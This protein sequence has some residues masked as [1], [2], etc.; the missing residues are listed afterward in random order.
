MFVVG[1]VHGHL[2]TLV[3]LL[4]TSGLIGD[5]HAWT[6]STAHLW[7]IGDLFDRGPDGVGVVEL[8]MRLEREATTAGG[9]VGA[10]LGNHDAMILAARRFGNLATSGPG[11]SFLTD[12][13]LNGGQD[14][15][16][17]RLGGRQIAWLTDRP[18]MALADGALLMHADATFYERYGA[19]VADVN[20]GIQH[21]LESDDPAAWDRLLDDF[22]QR[23]AFWE[24]PAE[25]ERLLQRY[26]GRC[27]IHGH[28]PI[29]KMTG[30]RDTDVTAALRYAG[31][32]CINVDGGIY[33]GGPGF[34]FEWEAAG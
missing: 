20:M 27:I 12:W 11:G 19:S 32:R 15:D 8:L 14:G 3:R 4:R 17:A 1:D 9:L 7:F 34:V 33:R 25:A 10:L 21:I 29:A 18:A 2:D 31:G 13:H 6:G 16:L 5:T 23:L 26:G 22:R 24:R 28:T 30:G